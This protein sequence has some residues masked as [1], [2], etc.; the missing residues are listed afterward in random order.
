MPLLADKLVTLGVIDAIAD[1]TV[2]RTRKN[3][4]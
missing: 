1:E 3:M 4:C 2:R